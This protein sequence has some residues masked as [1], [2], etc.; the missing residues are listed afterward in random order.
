MFCIFS[1]SIDSSIWIEITLLVL[2]CC[3]TARFP[4]HTACITWSMIE[5]GGFYLR[6]DHARLHDDHVAGDHRL[7][8]GFEGEQRTLDIHFA[9]RT[10]TTPR[11][12][13]DKSGPH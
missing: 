5:P 13:L 9:Q 4:A 11:C 6:D 12:T 2:A 10:Q 8:E 7:Q 3:T 1:V